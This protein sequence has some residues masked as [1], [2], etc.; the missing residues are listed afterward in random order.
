MVMGEDEIDKKQ[1][2]ERGML[3]RGEVGERGEEERECL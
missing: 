1:G 2:E 3:V